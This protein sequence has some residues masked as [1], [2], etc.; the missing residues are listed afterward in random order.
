MALYDDVAK[1]SI[2]PTCGAPIKYDPSSGRIRCSSCGGSYDPGTISLL[3][4]SDIK[5]TGDAN[6]SDDSTRKEIV[7]DSCGAMLIT[8]ENT[9]ATFCAFCGS[10]SLITRRLTREFRPDMV[11]PFKVTKDQAKAKFLEWA[12]G[13]KYA[14]G[15][16]TS[17]KNVEKLTGLYVPFWLIDAKC[18]AVGVGTG[19]KVDKEGYEMR[20]AQYSVERDTTF[21]VKHVPF[22]GSKAISDRLMEAI[23]PFDMSELRA[24][25]DDYLPGFFAERFD[26]TALDMAER[27]ES[28]LSGYARNVAETVNAPYEDLRLRFGSSYVEDYR[29]LYALLPVWFMNYR[30]EGI[31]Y[32]FAVNGQTGEAAGDIP[33][34]KYKKVFAVLR[35][36]IGGVLG[37][38]A[39]VLVFILSVIAF[40]MNMSKENGSAGIYILTAACSIVASYFCI[41][42]ILRAGRDA[43]FTATNPIDTAPTAEAYYDTARSATVEEKDK[44]IGME[45][46]DV[47]NG[48]W[49]PVC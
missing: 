21:Y 44:F 6:E 43:A 12:K 33:Y 42:H 23:E 49:K 7:C 37:T 27:I 11:L 28:R 16:F 25:S 2:C 9:S 18:H 39:S 20:R 35:S 5:D 15:D 48:R 41:R 19:Y 29:Q 3:S 8:D 34:S 24:Y 4:K 32:S 10:P 36:S 31:N 47:A 45:V 1:A 40:V 17:A 13:C 14:P 46:F 22:D 38:L 30:Y 26:L